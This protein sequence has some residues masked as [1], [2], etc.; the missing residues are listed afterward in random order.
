MQFRVSGFEGVQAGCLRLYVGF[1]VFFRDWVLGL[2]P[3]RVPAIL[4]C[5]LAKPREVF[6]WCHGI[7]HKGV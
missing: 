4:N 1:S 3:V 6:I 5:L 7:V 2:A